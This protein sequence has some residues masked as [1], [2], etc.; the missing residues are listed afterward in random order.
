MLNDQNISNIL[1]RMGF[2]HYEYVSPNNHSSGLEI[3]WNNGNIHAPALCKD[4]RAIHILVHDPE[5]AKNSI[6][7]GIYTPAQ[8]NQKEQFWVYLMDLHHIFDLPWCL[9]G[10]SNEPAN[11]LEKRGDQAL[12]ATQY[13]RLNSFLLNTNAESVHVKGQQFTWKKKSIRT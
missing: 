8:A 9:I 3:L 2:D 13:Q 5:I 10:D 12:S 1:P 4:T 11:P 6:T 7:S